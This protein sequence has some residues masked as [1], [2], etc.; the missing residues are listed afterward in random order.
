MIKLTVAALMALAAMGPLTQQVRIRSC[1]STRTALTS[2]S[3]Q[4]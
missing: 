2:T 4:L 3:Y 1:R